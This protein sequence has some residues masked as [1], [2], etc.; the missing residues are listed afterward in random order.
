MCIT[1]NR[2][3]GAILC[4]R[5]ISTMHVD[6]STST[7]LIKSPEY[8]WYNISVE[9]YTSLIDEVNRK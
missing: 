8:K 9:C 6:S 2:Y 7:F 3:N 4:D 5:Y 1:L